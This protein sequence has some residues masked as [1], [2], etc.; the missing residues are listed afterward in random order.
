VKEIAEVEMLIADLDGDTPAAGGL[1]EMSVC[2][3]VM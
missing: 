3:G 1:A 2:R